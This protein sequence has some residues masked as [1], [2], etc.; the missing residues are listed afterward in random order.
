MYRLTAHSG[1]PDGPCPQ[2]AFDE[3]RGKV[4]IQLYDLPAETDTS[5]LNPTPAGEHLG[6]MD[7]ATL[8]FMLAQHLDDAAWRRIDAMRSDLQAE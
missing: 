8:E 3:T 7:Q 5:L 1:C 2:M 4:A 6:E